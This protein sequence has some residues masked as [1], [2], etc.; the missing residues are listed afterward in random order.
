[1]RIY[2]NEI[3]EK[4]IMDAAQYARVSIERLRV[5]GSRK[6][7]RSFDVIL[8][9]SGARRSQ[10]ASHAFPSATWDEWGMFLARLFDREPGI[11]AGP[12]R[13]RD[14]FRWSTGARY[15][16]LLPAEQHKVHRW[17][18]DGECVTGAYIVHSCKGCPAIRRSEL[19][20]VA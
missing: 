17:Q 3:A 10:Y 9:G 12:Y 1:M 8:S 4:E 20:R 14:H 6:W 16:D 18:Y 2:T 7:E 15:D 13:D 5:R 11:K 19:R